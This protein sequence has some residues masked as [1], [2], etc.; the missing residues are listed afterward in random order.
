M[1]EK[2]P[3]DLKKITYFTDG[4]ASQYKCCKNFL[5][6]CKHYCDFGIEAEWHFF[7][8]SHGK[9]P[10][11]GIG[12]CVKRMATVHSL[13]SLSKDYIQTSFQMYEYLNKFKF[14]KDVTVAHFTDKDYDDTQKFL[15]VSGRLDAPIT[16]PGTQKLHCF[17]PT[18]DNE[19]EVRAYSSSPDSRVVKVTRGDTIGEMYQRNSDD[20]R[21]TFKK[22]D[23]IT[24]MY[25]E[26][27]WVGLIREDSD[28]DDMFEVSFLHPAG[29]M[30]STTYMF[31]TREDTLLVHDSDILT[32]VFP[33]CPTG[34]AYTLSSGDRIDACNALLEAL[35]AE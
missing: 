8:T 24:A 27:W 9:G 34:R 5:N 30:A 15:S 29:S 2:L 16:I 25:D 6:L 20:S 23:Y 35:Q 7:A 13:K 12:G 21:P 17:K 33:S 10:C 26:Q 32:K 28:G 22:M 18:S 31:P 1:K 4:C 14:D 19:L 11:D 3:F